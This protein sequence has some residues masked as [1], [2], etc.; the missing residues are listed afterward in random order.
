VSEIEASI[1]EVDPAVLRSV[2]VV[3]AARSLADMNRVQ[4]YDVCAVIGKPFDVEVLL[5]AVKQ[6]A[7]F[8]PSGGNL[9]T[10]GVILLLADFLR[11]RL[12]QGGVWR[13]TD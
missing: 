1:P 7:G 5:N 3:T 13:E 9:M 12:I 6:C 2:L 10:S 11:H 8:T 4:A